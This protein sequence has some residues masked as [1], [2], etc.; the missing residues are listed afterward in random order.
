MGDPTI[1]GYDMVEDL[2]SQWTNLPKS[3]IVAL[4]S[5]DVAPSTEWLSVPFD[6]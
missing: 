3:D 6:L 5:D 4:R 1:Y 2:L